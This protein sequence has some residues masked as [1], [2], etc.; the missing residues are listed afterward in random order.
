MKEFREGVAIQHDFHI[1]PQQS[2]YDM[3][4]GRDL[5]EPLEIDISY[6]NQTVTW[7]DRSIPLK[8]IDCTVEREFYTQEPASMDEATERI[9][10]ILDAKY[11]P[12]NL[13]EVV[14]ESQHLDKEEQR[15][16][17]RLLDKYRSLFDG[18]LGHW[19]GETYEV[20]LKT[21]ATPY[22]ARAY[23]IPKVHEKTLRMEVERLCEVG[24][25][26]RVNRSEWG[27]P[28]FIIPKNSSFHF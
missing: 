2:R 3:I 13:E 17:Y 25:L 11:E 15:L 14:Q 5:L 1:S 18:S 16:L 26:K 22:H 24:V 23:P 6:K 20:K 21:G 12:A 7:D 8:D 28:T 27:A 4:I 9:K 19:K 10:R